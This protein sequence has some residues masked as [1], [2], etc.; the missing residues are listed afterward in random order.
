MLIQ[1]PGVIRDLVKAG[2]VGFVET[3]VEHV[4]LLFVAKEG[5]CSKDH[6]CAIYLRCDPMVICSRILRHWDVKDMFN[7]TT[8]WMD[9]DMKCDLT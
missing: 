8:A 9:N 4:G 3:A 1:L 5:W 7:D 2:S 6:Y